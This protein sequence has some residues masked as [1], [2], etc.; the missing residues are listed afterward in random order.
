MAKPSSRVTDETE[1]QSP[2]AI[3][4]TDAVVGVQCQRAGDAL[5]KTLLMCPPL[6][7]CNSNRRLLQGVQG[8]EKET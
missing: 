6:S 3:S 4:T 2:S 1:M 5:P 8:R 7:D